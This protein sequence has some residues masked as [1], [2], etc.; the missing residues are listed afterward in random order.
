MQAAN[1]GR[2]IPEHL[3]RPGDF[4]IRVRKV[5]QIKI[6]KSPHYFPLHTS[7]SSRAK[8]S[9][10]FWDTEGLT[11]VG[12]CCSAEVSIASQP[13]KLGTGPSLAHV[14]SGECNFP[15]QRARGSH[16]GFSGRKMNQTERGGRTLLQPREAKGWN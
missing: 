4:L 10:Q 2:A 12:I 5:V 6:C 7:N 16:C 3:P 8:G 1:A 9:L 15:T 11:P 13:G 14:P